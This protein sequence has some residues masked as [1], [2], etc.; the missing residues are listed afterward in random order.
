MLRE[1]CSLAAREKLIG[2]TAFEVRPIAWVINLKAN[3]DFL[4]FSGT[5]EAEAA[6]EPKKGVKPKKPKE[7]AKKFTIPRQFNPDTGGTRTS[8]DYAYFLVDKSEYILGCALETKAGQPPSISKLIKRHRLFINK[9]K[10]CYEETKNEKLKAVL[11]FL[12]QIHTQGLPVDLPE[13][14]APGDL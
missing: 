6:P 9:V 14:T 10:A 13:M 8:G 5:H 7:V 4:N 12:E 3:G 11:V 2:D 1:L